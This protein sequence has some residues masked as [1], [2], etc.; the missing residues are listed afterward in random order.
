MRF[1]SMCQETSLVE[2][3]V[4]RCRACIAVPMIALV[5][6]ILLSVLFFHVIRSAQI[7]DDNV[8]PVQAAGGL[9]LSTV[10]AAL[11]WRERFVRRTLVGMG[12][13][14]VGLALV[15]LR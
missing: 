15:N 11:V 10:F 1:R 4:G 9:V 5:L 2:R 14:T 12:V 13:A 6:N 3:S 7:S 8:F